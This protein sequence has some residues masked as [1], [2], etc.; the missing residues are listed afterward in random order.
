MK[1]INHVVQ[2]NH[3]HFAT[4][5][6]AHLNWF[7]PF[8]PREKN[9]SVSRVT[10][11]KIKFTGVL[12]ILVVG[13]LSSTGLIKLQQFTNVNFSNLQKICIAQCILRI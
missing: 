5:K 3:A 6:Y 11:P 1:N 2:K 13:A 9:I 12:F 4:I 10:V 8:H 7:S